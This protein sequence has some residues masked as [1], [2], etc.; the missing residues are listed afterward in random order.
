VFGIFIDLETTGLD[1]HR[2]RVLEMA[3]KILDLNSGAVLDSLTESLLHPPE[4]FQAADPVSLK[5]NGWTQEESLFGKS[6]QEVGEK[7]QAL[8]AQYQIHRNNAFFIGQN[9]SFDRPFFSQ[10]VPVYR[11]E[12]LQWPYHW[13]DLASMYWGEKIKQ[14]AKEQS[15]IPEM[16]RLSKDVIA[17]ELGLA[18]EMKPHRAMNGVEHLI[19]CYDVLIGF[20]VKRS[21]CRASE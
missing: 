2:H 15:S 18:P 8:F 11:Q 1:W 20:P 16:T 14:L 10:L 3:I 21:L 19:A 13:L 5:V 9:P 6:E 7:V 4:V 17:F 12:K